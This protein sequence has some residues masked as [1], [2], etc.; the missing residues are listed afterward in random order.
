MFV[1]VVRPEGFK[2]DLCEDGTMLEDGTGLCMTYPENITV[3]TMETSTSLLSDISIPS[4]QDESQTK[5]PLDGKDMK[6]W[7]VNFQAKFK[8]KLSVIL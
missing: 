3:D 5:S 7:F 4:P 8:G 6:I 2:Y 1:Y